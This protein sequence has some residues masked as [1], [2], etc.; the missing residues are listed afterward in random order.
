[1]PHLRRQ[2]LQV[3]S[4]PKFHDRSQQSQ[5]FDLLGDKSFGDRRR[6][7]QRHVDTQPGQKVWVDVR[8]P[9]ILRTKARLDGNLQEHG[10]WQKLAALS[11]LLQSLQ[12]DVWTTKQVNFYCIII[13]DTICNVCMIWLTWFVGPQGNVNS[14][15]W[16][17]SDLHR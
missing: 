9:S 16:T 15:K 4:S 8:V 17:G 14:C 1:M 7:G 13:K 12:E 11:I 6:Q 3:I 5:Q 10:F 2:R